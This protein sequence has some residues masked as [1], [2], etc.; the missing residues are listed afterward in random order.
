MTEKHYNSV[1]SHLEHYV[2]LS[3]RWL[4]LGKLNWHFWGVFCGMN[5]ETVKSQTQFFPPSVEE[6]SLNP[7]WFPFVEVRKPCSSLIHIANVLQELVSNSRELQ[8]GFH[9]RLLQQ[10]RLRAQMDICFPQR[11]ME[12]HGTKRLGKNTTT[13]ILHLSTAYSHIFQ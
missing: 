4:K 6:E 2:I 11:I 7:V 8:T 9:G 12:R 10:D 13:P 1:W 5:L 3:V